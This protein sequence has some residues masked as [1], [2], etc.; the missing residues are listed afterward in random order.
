M[1]KPQIKLKSI[2]TFNGHEGMLGFNADLFIDGI[3]C[4][5][6]YDD[7]FGGC[8]DLQPVTH[9]NPQAKLI[10]TLIGNLN[11]YLDN[12]VKEPLIVFGEHFVDELS[13]EP[14]YKSNT[15]ED[16]VYDLFNDHIKKQD[17]KKFENVCKKS[18]CWGIPK[19]YQYQSMKFNKLLVEINKETLQSY[20]DQIKQ[21][22]MKPDE[23][24]L[25]KNLIALGVT[26]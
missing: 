25:N 6:V 23:V 15:I 18:I 20:V 16:I 13:G 12:L 19:G 8:V 24:I 1:K 17:V 5:H 22:H 21:L 14:Q 26:I 7:S 9:D 10:N 11:T 2:K 4:F 3:K